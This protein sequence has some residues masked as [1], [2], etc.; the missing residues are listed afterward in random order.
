[1][2][3]PM[4]KTRI[5]FF[6]V[7]LVLAA[8]G[9]ATVSSTSAG[10]TGPGIETKA[11]C[12]G[13]ISITKIHF[14]PPSVARGGHSTVHVTARNCTGQSQ[15]IRLTWLGQFAGKHLSGCPVI[16][17][18]AR[19][20]TF[21]SHGTFRSSVGYDVPSSCTASRLDA[22][23]RFSG[24]GGTQLAEGSADLSITK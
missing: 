24:S 9:V 12:S 7:S 10:W 15:S 11:P 8:V 18:L 21:A 19:P 14:V 1:V 20:A 13:T 17:P 16:D 2:T 22:T 4:S 3:V 6:C 23:A 5:R